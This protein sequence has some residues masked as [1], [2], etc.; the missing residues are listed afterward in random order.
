MARSADHIAIGGITLP[1][2]R[3]AES[4]L[5]ASFRHVIGAAALLGAVA[6]LFPA[7]AGAGPTDWT[8][9]RALNI[10]HQGGEDEA[11]SATMYA[12]ERSMK[13]GSDMLEVDVNTTK[14]DRLAIIHDGEVDRTTNGT[15]P[16]ADYM[17][18]ELKKLD[19]AQW[20]APL[21]GTTD[22]APKDQ[23]V[24][25][26]VRIGKEKP[27]PAYGRGDFRPLEL[28]ELMDRYPGM[29]INIEIKGGVAEDDASYLH[30]AEVLAEF[31]ND[32]GRTK[33]IVVAS[34][35]DAALTSFHQLAPK[36]DLAPAT[37]AV[38][39]YVL[40]GV[41]LPPGYEVFQVPTSFQGI[42]VVTQDFVD[43]AHGD[44]YAVHVWTIND[45]QTMNELWGYGVDG[46]MSAEPMRLEKNMCERNEPRPPLP[47]NSPGK[48]CAKNVS[49]A[50]EVKVNDVERIGRKKA[51]VTLTRKDNFD[52]RCAGRA[53]LKAIGAKAR[54]QAKFD[55][56]WHSPEAG[57]PSELVATVKLNKKL[58]GSIR[59]NGKV[60]ALTHPYGGFVVRA[61]KVA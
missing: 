60:R 18:A 51:A 44:G 29:P 16:V 39:G 31:L 11:P 25:R 30:V 41:P 6:L 28:A 47:K 7:G 26:G 1:L 33:G 4:L 17:M 43:G 52:S 23:Y 54:K 2:P 53:T 35:N 21:E 59:R 5:R 38:A 15:G 20:F 40:G 48:H 19:A 12:F 37:G 32:Y 10:T 34:F 22:D 27:P 24:F 58:R 36:I 45:E 13:L 46:I 14:D 8:K 55:F 56:G 42:P 9:L 57:G 3:E 61:T 50:C 49:I